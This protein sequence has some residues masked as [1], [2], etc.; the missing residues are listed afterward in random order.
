VTLRIVKWFSFV[1]W[2]IAWTAASSAWTHASPQARDAQDV[3]R[4]WYRLVLELARHTPTYSPP[5]ASR[6]FG[7]IGIAAYEAVASGRSDLVSLSG[8]LG[9]M[10]LMPKREAGMVYDERLVLHA[11]MGTMVRDLFSNTGPTGQRVIDRLESR[12]GE[13][14]M[15]TAD[16]VTAPRSRNHGEAIARAVLAWS[17]SDGGAVIEN[18]GFPLSYSLQKGPAYWVPTSTLQQQQFPLLPSWGTNR[19]FVLENGAACPL[20]APVAYSE[21]KDSAFYKQAAEVRDTVLRLTPEQRLIARFWS[22][23]PMLSPT[24]P[25]HW[26]SI[27]LQLLEED[28]ADIA[29]HVDVMARLGIAVADSFIANWH[30]KYDVNLLRPVTYIKRVIDPKWE[31]ILIT[32]PFP[33][34]P[35]GHSTQS[36]AAADV[37]AQ[38]FGKERAFVDSRWASPPHL[39]Q[40][41]GSG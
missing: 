30:V 25:G 4:T 10:P 26:L 39:R 32:P 27:A 23:D 37:L 17:Q 28:R 6:S 19:T 33:E 11:A 14:I 5:V 15:Q 21:D 40:L 22:D 31:P 38:L 1:C 3:L 8:Q 24:P 20:P 7:Y 35:S 36:G 9:A 13:T 16:P 12:L 2:L 29:R 18:M 41:S 34:Y